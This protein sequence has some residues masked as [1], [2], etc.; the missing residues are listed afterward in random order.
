M[1]VYQWVMDHLAWGQQAHRR[2]TRCFMSLC[3]LYRVCLYLSAC[4]SVCLS[5]CPSVCLS[6]CLSA[7][8]SLCLS[9][10]LSACLSL[11]LSVCL[12][13]CL[14]AILPLCLSVNFVSVP[15]PFLWSRQIIRPD[16]LGPAKFSASCYASLSSSGIKTGT[17]QIMRPDELGQ[18]NVCKITRHFSRNASRS[19][20][21]LYTFCTWRADS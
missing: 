6:F 20:S 11:C 9:L 2:H 1:S 21:R 10:C 4:L 12:S 5:V 14:S 19:L 18:D 15:L 7:C 16:E 8:L 3:R 13:L 17:R